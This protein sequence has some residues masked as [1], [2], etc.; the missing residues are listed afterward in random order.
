M[1]SKC[2]CMVTGGVHEA[3]TLCSQRPA[4][5]QTDAIAGVV[6]L[7]ML[8]RCLLMPVVNRRSVQGTLQRSC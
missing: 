5:Q 3:P 2:L 1:C 8:D 4:W 6:G 7:I